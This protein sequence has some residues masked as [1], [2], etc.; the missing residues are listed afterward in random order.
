MKKLLTEICAIPSQT[1][2]EEAC[3]QFLYEKLTSEAQPTAHYQYGHSHIYEF[4]YD[5]TKPVL[6]LVGH[7]DVVP[8]HFEPYE[9]DMNIHG[10]GASDMKAGVAAFV[11]LLTTDKQTLCENMN[12]TL[13]LYVKEEQTPITENG[14]YE[15]IQ[16][17]PDIIKKIDCAIVGEPTDNTIQLGCVGSLHV[18][19]SVKGKAAHSARPWNGENALYKALPLIQ[20]IAEQKPIAQTI[21]GLE[22]LDVISITESESEAGRTTIPG[23]WTCNLNYRFA[24]NKTEAEALTYVTNLVKKSLNNDVTI[25]VKDSVYA[26]NIIETPF[27]KKVIESLSCDIEAKQAWT[28]VAQLAKCGVPAFNFGPGYQYF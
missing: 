20:A 24:P 10:A 5:K 7:L 3:A 2:D 17:Y 27:S 8:K 28:D 16:E 4:H 11:H 23:T 1:Y 21:A 12:I 9:K 18:T 26:G 25:T 22:F 6:G 13:I 15:L 14:L 19:V